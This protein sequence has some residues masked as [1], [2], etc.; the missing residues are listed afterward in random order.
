MSTP[1]QN[2]YAAPVESSE[3]VGVNSGTIDDLRAVARYQRGVIFCLLMYLSLMIIASVV[4]RF[5]R[6]P[7][8]EGVY[9]AFTAF[10]LLTSLTGAVFAFLLAIK[11][12]R[13]LTGFLLGILCLV[14]CI[15]LLILLLINGKATTVLKENGIKVGF[16][17]A[18]NLP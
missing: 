18:K 3:V 15:N 16:M 6:P 17:G 13:G 4:V 2:P 11:V 12:Y 1:E 7:F 14:P 9:F 5:P 10:T 8:S